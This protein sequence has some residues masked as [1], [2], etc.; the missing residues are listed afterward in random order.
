MSYVNRN[1]SP[2]SLPLAFGVKLFLLISLAEG[3]GAQSNLALTFIYYQWKQSSSISCLPLLEW[4]DQPPGAACP[5]P[6]ITGGTRKPS[7][8]DM[9]PLWVTSA[10]GGEPASQGGMS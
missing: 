8:G 5:F 7:R 6:V 10:P 1:S 3:T 2:G 9:L 4:V